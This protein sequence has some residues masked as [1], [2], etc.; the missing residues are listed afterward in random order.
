MSTEKDSKKMNILGS[1]RWKQGLILST[2]ALICI[3][4]SACDS[5]GIMTGGPPTGNGGKG[6]TKVGILLPESAT[7][8]RWETKDHP[9]L[10]QAVKDAIPGVQIDYNN[11]QSNS[12]TQLKQAQAALAH[13]DCILIVAPHDSVGAAPIVEQAKAANVPVIAYDRLIQSKNLNYYV[14]FD[15]T[16]VGQMQGQ[17]IAAHY[18][19]YQRA[20]KANLVMINGSQTDNNA[21]LYSIGS[22]AALDPLFAN[23]SLKNISE[24]FTPDWNNSTAQAEMEAYLTDQH[25]DIQ[26]A[27]VAND[28]MANKVITALKTAGLNGKVLVTGQ[29]ATTTG[30][31]NILAG[32]QGMTVYKPIDRLARSAGKLVK[33]L[34]DGSN[35]AILTKNV[36]VGTFD[37][38]NVPAILGT[39][40][41]VDRDNIASTV[42]ADEFIAKK[43]VCDGIP[44]GT[45]NVC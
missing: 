31:H 16:A 35:V 15:N 21:L 20:G 9:L 24:T 22:H 12:D 33:A 2:I 37:G 41:T 36:M 28:G 45:A 25:N 4:L 5:G 11:A 3:T 30:I 27:Y 29:D 10:V 6:C 17:Y 38:G 39:P 1:T 23:G 43:D 18:Q 42:I 32:D 8:D 26:V 7:S 44:V 13:G 19:Q 34:Y 40:I 14:S